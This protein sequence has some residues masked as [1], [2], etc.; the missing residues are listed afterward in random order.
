MTIVV[1]YILLAS[2]TAAAGRVPAP[3]EDTSANYKI[4]DSGPPFFCMLGDSGP[5][6]F[7]LLLGQLRQAEY[8]LLL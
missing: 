2:R 6:F 5:L 3:P 4:G 7:Y 1:P 8:Q